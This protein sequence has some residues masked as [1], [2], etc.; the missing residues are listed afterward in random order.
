M[1]AL[2]LAPITAGVAVPD[3]GLLTSSS[4][5]NGASSGTIAFANGASGAGD[6]ISNAQLLAATSGRLKALLSQ[7][8]ATVAAM[9]QAF[10]AAGLEVSYPQGASCSVL[11]FTNAGPGVPTATLTTAAATGW[12]R[13]S[14]PH[15]ATA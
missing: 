11:A 5:A 3:A 10:A 14:L 4:N 6:T 2:T 8:Y 15:S 9:T 13:L 1:A 7:S 12:F